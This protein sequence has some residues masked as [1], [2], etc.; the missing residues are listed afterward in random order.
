MRR[1]AINRLDVTPRFQF[2]K[3][4]IILSRASS[5]SV[6]PPPPR[7]DVVEIISAHSERRRRVRVADGF[8]AW[9]MKV[10]EERGKTRSHRFDN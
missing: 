10:E 4:R 9:T 6:P 2:C 3:Q 8:C 5:L 7:L 1:M